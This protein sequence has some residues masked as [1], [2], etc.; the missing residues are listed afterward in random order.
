MATK[1][2][3]EAKIQFI[4]HSAFVLAIIKFELQSSY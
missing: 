3:D 1:N 4:L 2:F